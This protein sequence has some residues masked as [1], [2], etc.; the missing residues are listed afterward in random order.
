MKF[1]GLLTVVAGARY[2]LV[3]TLTADLAWAA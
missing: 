2:D 1:R 3:E